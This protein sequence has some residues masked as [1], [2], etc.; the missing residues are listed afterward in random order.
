MWEET[1]PQNSSIKHESLLLDHDDISI[2]FSLGL[3]LKGGFMQ[4]RIKLCSRLLTGIKSFKP[5]FLERLH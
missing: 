1:Y 2:S 4:C 3:G 5:V